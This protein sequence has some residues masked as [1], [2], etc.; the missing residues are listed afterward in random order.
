MLREINAAARNNTASHQ[1]SQSAL[2]IRQMPPPTQLLTES[3]LARQADTDLRTV[4]V[5]TGPKNLDG[6][7]I[8]LLA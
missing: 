8:N 5:D 6:F 7:Q 2:T 3:N 1:L 4:G